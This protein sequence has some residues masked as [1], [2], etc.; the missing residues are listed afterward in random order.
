[1]IQSVKTREIAVRRLVDIVEIVIAVLRQPEIVLM[2]AAM[3]TWEKNV[4][5]VRRPLSLC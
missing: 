5:Q 4:T 2:D 1:M 3:V